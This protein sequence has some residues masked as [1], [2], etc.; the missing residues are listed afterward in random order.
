M[1]PSLVQG[2]G[3]AAASCAYSAANLT[4]GNTLFA[5]VYGASTGQSY[6]CSDGTNGA[7]TAIAATKYNTTYAS[8][9]WFYKSNT[10]GGVK[11]T[12][13]G[14]GGTITGILIAEFSG[15]ANPFVVDGAAVAEGTSATPSASVTVGTAGDLVLGMCQVANTGTKGA[16]FTY[17]ADDANGDVAEYTIPGSSGALSVSFTQTSGLFVVSAFACTASGAGA[18]ATVIGPRRMPLGV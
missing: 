4:A 9:Q 16:A 18:S 6:T 7:Y 5:A 11:P 10:A 3:A 12:V 13:T 17:V 15:V 8:V 1:T 14:A 2:K